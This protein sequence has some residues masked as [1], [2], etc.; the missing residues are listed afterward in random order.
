[1]AGGVLLR[2]AQVQDATAIA[3]LHA[4]SWRRHYRG[5][6][7]DDYLDGDLDVDRLEAWTARL[8]HPKANAVTALA[9]TDGILVGFVHALVDHDVRWGSLI[10]NLHV[11]H[12]WQRQGVGRGL[13]AAAATGVAE[14]SRHAPVHL[15]VL[16]Q[17]SRAQAFYRALGGACVEH[18]LCPAPGGFAERLH[19]TPSR[20]RFVWP[21]AAD[22]VGGRDRH[23]P[24]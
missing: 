15:W 7:A 12:G 8:E 14:I 5:A 4:E 19:G 3:A 2:P 24:E 17:N 18:A 11:R 23:R 13:M 21:T 10:E 1:M 22:I 16:Q 9:E 6:Y 20:L